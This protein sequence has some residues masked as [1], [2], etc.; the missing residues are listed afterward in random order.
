M[1]TRVMRRKLH[2]TSVLLIGLMILNPMSFALAD[3]DYIEARQ[4]QESGKI[5]P[6]ELILQHVRQTY[7]GK[8][9]DVELENEEG[10]IIYEVEILAES[11]IVIEVYINAETGKILIA[12]EDD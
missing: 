2:I 1:Y 3:D 11:G 9:L 5:L 7:P 6:L 4:L 10:R 12:K 8:V